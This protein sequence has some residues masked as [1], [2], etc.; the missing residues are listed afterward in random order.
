MAA[1]T[2]AN[3]P[4]S[5]FGRFASLSAASTGRHSQQQGAQGGHH[6]IIVDKI[7]TVLVS[8]RQICKC[9]IL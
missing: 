6:C 7:H 9:L 2:T 3:T 4:E 8:Q 5:E 1:Y